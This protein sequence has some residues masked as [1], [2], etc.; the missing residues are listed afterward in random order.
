M[1]GLLAIVVAVSLLGWWAFRTPSGVLFS[2]LSEQDTAVVAQELDKLK[3]PYEI[4]TGDRSVLVPQSTVHKTRMA[5]M[6][7]DLPLHGAVGFELFNNADFGVSDFVQKVNY[8]RALQGELTRTILSIEEVESARV[9]LAIPDQELFRKDSEHAKAS[10]TVVTKRGQSLSAAQVLGIQRLV[11][12]SVPDIH[13]EDVTVLDQRGVAL[14]RPAGDEAALAPPGAMDARADLEAALAQKATEVLDRAFGSHSSLVTVAAVMNRQQVKVTTEEVLPAIG[15]AKNLPPAGV[16]VREHT[17]SRDASGDGK[18]SGENTEDVDYQTGKRVEQVVS[19]AGAVARLNVA[20]VL[21]RPLDEVQLKHARELVTAAVGLQSERGDELAIYSASKE[22]V[23][24]QDA[25]AVAVVSA[26]DKP[27]PARSL[28]PVRSLA[29]LAL[30]AAV[31]CAA[32]IA[33]AVGRRSR[34]NSRLPAQ[35]A[36][37][38]LL[39]DAQREAVLR[40]VQGWLTAPEGARDA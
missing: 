38:A 27:V 9:H 30:A 37:P 13:T 7:H 19:P 4:G 29:I 11:S 2:D 5:L 14:S 8:Q 23:A 33:W 22:Q 28:D 18:G 21:Q 16:I 17:V 20:V 6:A 10:V 34:A 35:D 31:A 26:P 1:L 3:V 36:S 40:S 39:S 24:A 15:R 32:A 25:P 12:A